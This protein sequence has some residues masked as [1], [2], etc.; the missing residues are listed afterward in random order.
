MLINR[1]SRKTNSV[2]SLTL[3]ITLTIGFS[4]CARQ[5]QWFKPGLNQHEFEQDAAHCRKQAAKSTYQ[6]PFAFNAG[7]MDG[8]EQ[9]MVRERFFERCMT[10][11]GYRLQREPSTK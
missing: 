2:L 4:G 1:S 10:A 6:S 7:E 5:Q 11:K 9:S 8:L 3:L